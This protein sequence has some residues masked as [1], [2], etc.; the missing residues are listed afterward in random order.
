MPWSR[1]T[2]SLKASILHTVPMDDV[3]SGTNGNVVALWGSGFSLL[4][5]VVLLITV[6][7]VHTSSAL[8]YVKFPLVLK[9]TYKLGKIIHI[10]TAFLESAT[11]SSSWFFL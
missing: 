4:V 10:K 7:L 11:Y 5:S 8:E 1:E 6:F 9:V 3:P 2:L